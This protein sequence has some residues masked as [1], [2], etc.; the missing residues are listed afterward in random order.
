MKDL[1][2]WWRIGISRISGPKTH[3]MKIANFVHGV[4]QRHPSQ[5]QHASVYGA[6]SA[7]FE[8]DML[9]HISA[10]RHTDSVTTSWSLAELGEFRCD[11][12]YA[13]LCRR[14]YRWWERCLVHRGEKI[15]WTRCLIFGSEANE[16]FLGPLSLGSILDARAGFSSMFDYISGDVGDV[17]SRQYSQEV[18]WMVATLCPF[19]DRREYVSARKVPRCALRR[20]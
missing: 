13:R 12:K 1:E 9:S 15:H 18:A 6:D 5:S 2:S 19:N 11:H 10:Q 7:M 3:S 17:A 8:I 16:P 4:W 14:R 20:I